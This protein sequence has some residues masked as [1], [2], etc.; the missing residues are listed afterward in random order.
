MSTLPLSDIVNVSINVGPVSSVR[1]GFNVALIVGVSA[2]IS[3]KTRV[4]TYSKIGDMSEDGWLGTEPEYLAAQIYFSQSPIPSSVVIGRWDTT[5][6][7]GETLAETAVQAITAC[8]QA[9][10]E[11]YA[12]ML[13][14]ATKQDIVAIAAYIDSALPVATFFY[15]T[16]DPDI[17]LGT[18][19]N[20]MDTLKKSSVHRT[21]GQYSTSKYSNSIDGTST[22]SIAAIMGYAMG[23]NTQTAASAYT[24]AYKPEVGITAESLTGGQAK[25]IKNYNG[26]IY[27][28]RGTVYNLFEDGKTADGT[29]FDEVL[30]LDILANNIQAAVMNTFIDLPKVPQTDPG[31]A[32][33]LNAITASLEAARTTGFIADGVWSA[34][35]M[36]T[37][38]TGDVLPRGYAILAGTI[39]SQTQADRDNR[40]SPPIYILIKSAGAIQNIAI[41]LYINR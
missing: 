12:C 37:V 13:C 14:N 22:D 32:T 34:A 10:S 19:G 1:T 28:N 26:N 9:N 21:I 2:I 4:K 41:G 36:L 23:S 30:N 24:L 5:V 11:W 16:S 31:M 35:P 39:A 29:Y 8:R 15:T 3:S 33:L 25:I 27:V 38:N 20:I 6:Q 17:L 40:I 18:S 7:E